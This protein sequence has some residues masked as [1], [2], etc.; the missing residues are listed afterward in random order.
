[1]ITEVGVFETESIFIL[2][3]LRTE[4]LSTQIFNMSPGR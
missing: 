4:I 3:F 2:N 1:M